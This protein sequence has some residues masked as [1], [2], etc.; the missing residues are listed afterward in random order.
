MNIQPVLTPPKKYITQ[1]VG[2]H[3]QFQALLTAGTQKLRH[4]IVF[5]TFIS[6]LSGLLS[7]SEVLQ[8]GPMF[9]MA[10]P[11]W[12]HSCRKKTKMQ[13]QWFTNPDGT[14]VMP[15]SCQCGTCPTGQPRC[16]TMAWSNQASWDGRRFEGRNNK[17][18]TTTT[19]TTTP[20]TPATTATA[21]TTTTT[22]TTTIT[23]TM[24]T[25]TTLHFESWTCV[26]SHFSMVS[27]HRGSSNSTRWCQE[28]PMYLLVSK[29]KQHPPREACWISTRLSPSWKA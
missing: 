7:F 27:H 4:M 28:S 12:E 21:T 9:Q 22:T 13:H 18:A 24:T 1:H 2:E 19:T 14:M 25:T 15:W 16:M 29:K 20:A 6:G 3:H 26:K 10:P 8:K 5:Q 11:F 23:T 17:H